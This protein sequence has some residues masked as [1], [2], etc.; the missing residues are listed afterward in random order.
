MGA[1]CAVRILEGDYFEVAW[2]SD[3]WETKNSVLS[4]NLGS[5]GF[6]ADIVPPAGAAELQ[7]TLHWPKSDRWL[8]YNVKVKIEAAS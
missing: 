1:G 5:A 8:G 2:S 6:S 7:W 3:N 4:R